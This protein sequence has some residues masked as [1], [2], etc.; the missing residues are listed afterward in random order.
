VGSI[1]VNPSGE[2]LRL[3][4]LEAVG[5]LLELHHKPFV[6][7]QVFTICYQWCILH[8]IVELLAG[9]LDEFLDVTVDTCGLK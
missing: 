1:A 2:Y 9:V 5:F 7:V 8:E 6:P 3:E 4:V